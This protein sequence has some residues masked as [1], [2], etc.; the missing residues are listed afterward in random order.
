MSDL[1]LSLLVQMPL[2][3]P[4]AWAC[5]ILMGGLSRAI[6][7]IRRLREQH[8]RLFREYARL[9]VACRDV[10]NWFDGLPVDEVY[11]RG[12]LA[13]E[14]VREALRRRTPSPGGRP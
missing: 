7:T 1:L 13:F 10:A 5:V 2:T 8:E 12:Y 11:A 3:L 9:R 14:D 4:I 6:E